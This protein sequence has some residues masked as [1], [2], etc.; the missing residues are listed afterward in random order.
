M[1]LNAVE[2]KELLLRRV[3]PMPFAGW[4]ETLLLFKVCRERGDSYALSFDELGY[5]KN[6]ERFNSEEIVKRA[7]QM[8]SDDDLLRIAQQN[9]D[10]LSSFEEFIGR[11]Y[12]YFG[13]SKELRLGSIWKEVAE[14]AESLATKYEGNSFWAVLKAVWKS[15]FVEER[16]RDNWWMVYSIAKEE[17]LTSGWLTIIE[18]LSR[19][20]LIERYKGDL[21]IPPERRQLVEEL[22]QKHCSFSEEEKRY[23]SLT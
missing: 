2:E 16:R 19:C 20:H 8:L 14:Q 13:A 12:T 3:F 11:Y 1:C 7:A 22:L 6:Y 21:S 9:K 18:D 15:N 17:G 10:Q 5:T 4:K 23:L